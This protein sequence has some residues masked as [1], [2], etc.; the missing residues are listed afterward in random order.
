MTKVW[1]FKAMFWTKFHNK[2]NPHK[3]QTLQQYIPQMVLPITWLGKSPVA[4]LRMF[5]HDK[6]CY[7]FLSV[8]TANQLVAKSA[9]QMAGLRTE[10]YG[11]EFD[12]QLGQSLT[13]WSL[14]VLP[15]L[16]RG[17]LWVFPPTI[18]LS[19]CASWKQP[20]HYLQPWTQLSHSAS[21]SQEQS[22][23]PAAHSAHQ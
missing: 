18:K 15:I 16:A 20:V 22:L 4:G 12:S 2:T 9:V 21:L 5:M 6:A 17:F 23:T 14:H 10:Y 3:L 7:L 19:P 1:N 8:L 13:V 11:R